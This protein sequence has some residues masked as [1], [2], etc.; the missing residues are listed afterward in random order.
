MYWN[1]LSF[2]KEKIEYGNHSIIDVSYNYLKNLLYIAL[3][4]Y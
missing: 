3:Y 2:Y 4:N 1:H